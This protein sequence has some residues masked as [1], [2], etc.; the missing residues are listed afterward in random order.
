MQQRHAVFVD[1]KRTRTQIRRLT[2]QLEH[3]QE[4]LL[5]A[6]AFLQIEI[7]DAVGDGEL[8]S[9]GQVGA[10]VFADQQRRATGTGQAL[11]Q[12]VAKEAK[13]TSDGGKITQCAERVDD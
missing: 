12:V 7:K 9:G 10:I 8:G 11:G 3:L 2:A 13:F 5:F 6:G 4:T 1:Q